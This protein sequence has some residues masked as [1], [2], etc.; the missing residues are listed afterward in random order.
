IKAGTRASPGLG[1]STQPAV[2][3]T[4]SAINCCIRN[5]GDPDGRMGILDRPRVDGQ[6][7]EGMELTFERSV[8]A[9]PDE[10]QDLQRLLHESPP[11]SEVS[12]EDFI[13][14]GPPTEAN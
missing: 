4:G 10:T 11:L 3:Q 14:E 8:L 2:A 12:S 1:W 5:S 7:W 13:F 9:C 6:L